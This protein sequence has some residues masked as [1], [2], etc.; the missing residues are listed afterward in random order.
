MNSRNALLFSC[1]LTLSVSCANIRIKNGEWC[2]DS[3]PEGATCF[4]SLNVEDTRD[5]SRDTWDELAIGPDHRFGKVCTDVEN[6]GEWKKAL[7]KLCRLTRRCTF[8]VKNKVVAF[9]DKAQSV[10]FNLEK[11][12]VESSE[13]GEEEESSVARKPNSEIFEREGAREEDSTGIDSA[14]ET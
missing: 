12:Y 7:L 6:F 9:V 5:I 3:G 2:A 14:E 1:V 4:K 11:N 13:D 8:D 10:K